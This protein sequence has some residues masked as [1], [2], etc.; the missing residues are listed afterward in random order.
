MTDHVHFIGIAG[1]G[2]SAIARLLFEQGTIVTGSDRAASP[3]G[4]E[5]AR[6]GIPVTIGHAAANISGASWVV[7]SSAIPDD[8]PEVVAAHDQ[9]I[10]VYKRSDFLGKL[11]ES[12]IVGIAIAGTHGKTTTTGLAAH[13]LTALGTD[14]SYIVGSNII[15][16]TNAHFG[17]G[18]PFVIEADEYDRMFLGLKPRFAVITNLEHD[19]PDIY[20]T[21]QEYTEAFR[22]FCALVPQDGA[23]IGCFNE[24]EVISLFASPD[25]LATRKVYYGIAGEF[26]PRFPNQ[27]IASPIT[28]KDDA[29]HYAIRSRVNGIE[30]AYSLS[31]SLPGLHNI[32]NAM[33]VIAIVE[34]IGF[35]AE[36]AKPAFLSFTGTNRRFE[37][38][39]LGNGILGINDYAH[40]PT[41]IRATLQAARSAFPGKT[42]WAVWQPHTYSRTKTLFNAFSRSFAD[43]DHVIVSEIYRSREPLEDFSSA[44]L[45][46]AMRHPSALYINQLSD[47]SLY[48]ASHLKPGDILLIMSAGDADT[49][50]SDLQTTFRLQGKP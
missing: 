47:I 17:K 36:D 18:A 22:Q 30:R 35:S 40:H 44:S 8:N 6:L 31:L 46:E 7:R 15:G 38:T 16:S 26:D 32:K 23:L 39:P 48:L 4:D 9:G 49:I 25:L 11:M 1:S 13:V 14:P 5:L 34:L 33:A 21:Y 29:F 19:H 24:Q 41:E 20:P 2:L 43:A 50:L 10:P 3:F 28:S 45:V 37:R 12:P 27:V 42:L